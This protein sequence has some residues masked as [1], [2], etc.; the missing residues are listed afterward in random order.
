M[1]AQRSVWIYVA[2]FFAALFYETSA[3]SKDCDEYNYPKGLPEGYMLDDTCERAKPYSIDEDRTREK[4]AKM[5]PLIPKNITVLAQ[6]P[7]DVYDV[8]IFWPAPDWSGNN[9]DLI[10]LT[11][12]SK[13]VGFLPGEVESYRDRT[14]Y[15]LR[16]PSVQNPIVVWCWRTE[17]AMKSANRK[18]SNDLVKI[19]IPYEAQ[20]CVLEKNLYKTKRVKKDPRRV[21]FWCL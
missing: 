12:E 3:W 14:L 18:S 17:S 1:K 4:I 16:F 11:G 20:Y 9:F 8:G 5:V 19:F 7:F 15:W 6:C 13:G 2:I 21:R 10:N